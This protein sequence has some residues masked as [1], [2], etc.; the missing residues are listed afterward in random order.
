MSGL[1]VDVAVSGP[2]FDG[3]AEAAAHASCEV[4]R[5]ALGTKGEQLAFI[6][7]TGS[8]RDDHG[9]FTSQFTQTDHSTVYSWTS[10]WT[11]DRVHDHPSRG[12]ET[13]I[14]TYTMPITVDL[15]NETVVTNEL[16]TYGP[17]LEG[18]GSR[19]LT[20]R[21]KGYHGMRKAAQVLNGMAEAIGEEAM[22]PF[23][24]EMNA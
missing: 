15:E 5:H 16:A 23:V 14:R 10:Q 17:W 8:I 6:A 2:V 9:V 3:R 19:N 11:R 22:G 4:I 18:T 12:R 21:F 1:S 24:D 7:F 13:V 20:T